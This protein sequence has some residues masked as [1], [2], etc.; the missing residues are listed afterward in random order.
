MTKKEI[1]ELVNHRN[2]LLKTDNKSPHVD[3]IAKQ[4]KDV[5]IKKFNS[6]EVDFIIETLTMFGEAPNLM[7]DDNGYFAVSGNG[8]QPVV[9]GKQKIEGLLSV[10]VEKQQWK[11]T[12]RLALKHYLLN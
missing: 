6:Y 8:Y 1:I 3:E 10:Y 12:I 11:K 7:Y 2:Y 5:F 4:V 9:Y